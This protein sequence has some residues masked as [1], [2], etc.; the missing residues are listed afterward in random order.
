MARTEDPGHIKGPVYIPNC[1]AVRLVWTLPN[2]KTANNILHA[3]YSAPPTFTQA[4]VNT[5][6]TAITNAFTSSGIRTHL[7]TETT[8]AHV[9]VRDMRKD[10]TTGFGF[11]EWL[12]DNA[13]VAGSAGGGAPLPAQTA[14]VV[15]LKTGLSR[16][17]NRGRVYIPGFNTAAQ[18]TDGNA[19]DQ[20]AIDCVDFV[21]GVKDAL[22][23]ASYQMC[24][25]HPARQAYNNGAGVDYPARPAGTV[26]VVSAVAL[27][28]V[29]DTQRLRSHV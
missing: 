8:L 20:C 18:G 22:T 13:G 15:S 5:L 27:N 4:A 21:V 12:S 26:L 1:L 11:G 23:A 7:D 14:F 25:A 10:D 16:Q 2:G 29:F 24:I 3:R 19:S 6:F 9:G 28:K 17:A